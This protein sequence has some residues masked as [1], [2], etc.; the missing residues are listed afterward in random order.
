MNII[1]EIKQLIREQYEA[2][3]RPW[4]VAYSGGKDTTLVL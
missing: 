1:D 3:E 4:V 2:D